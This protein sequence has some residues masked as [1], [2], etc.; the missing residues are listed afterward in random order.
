[1]IHIL[2]VIF[3]KWMHKIICVLLKC[4]VFHIDTFYGHVGLMLGFRLFIITVILS[5]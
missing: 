1:M 3:I 4:Y 2:Q 5:I